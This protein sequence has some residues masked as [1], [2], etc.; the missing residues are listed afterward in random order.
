MKKAISL[1]IASLLIFAAG[2]SGNGSSSPAPTPTAAASLPVS[3]ESGATA[4][5]DVSMWRIGTASMT[6]NFYTLGSALAQMVNEKLEG[7]E[8]AAQATG[9]S[10]D[11]CFLLNDKEIEIGLIQSASAQEAV[12][13]TGAFSETGK[14][15]SMQGVGVIYLM[16]FHCIVNNKSNVEKI[17]DLQG[18]KIGVGPMGGG[19]EVNANI[20]LAEFGVT[21][22]TPIYGTMGEALDG[23]KNGEVDAVIYATATGSA[24]VSDALNSGNC[25]LIGMTNEQAAKI[26]SS[27][28]EFGPDVIPAGSY[29]EQP[30]DIY[31]FAGSALILTRQDISEEAI[32]QF[33]KTFYESNDFLV[34][35]NAI[36]ADSKLEN[37]TVGMCVALH[38]GAQKYFKE[39]GAL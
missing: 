11:N 25:R 16:P 15:E 10:A 6:G 18:K 34:S 36:F 3:S 22:F 24:N 30:Q 37:A 38:P 33:C 17:T 19:V 7:G 9:G 23:V 28:P 29:Q 1:M 21:D 2:C 14:I 39:K 5:S 27:R 8:A 20:L 35:Q 13:G 31:T 32:Y 26:C 4:Q 12:S